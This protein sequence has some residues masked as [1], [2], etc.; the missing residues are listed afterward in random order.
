MPRKNRGETDEFGHG[1]DYGNYLDA[2]HYDDAMFQ[3]IWNTLQ[4]DPFYKDQTALLI[5]PDHGRG[6]GPLWTSHGGRADPAQELKPC[7]KINFD[8]VI[9]DL[10]FHKCKEFRCVR[11]CFM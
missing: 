1:G 4:A 7:Q 9:H 6:I 8:L 2:A 5:M 10:S 11:G 3:D